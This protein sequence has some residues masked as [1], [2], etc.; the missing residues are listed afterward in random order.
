MKST[1]LYAVIALLIAAA[2]AAG[3]VTGAENQKG[4][5]PMTDLTK[6]GRI[7][8]PVITSIYTADPSA[9]VGQDGRLYVYASHDMDPARGCDFMDRY[10]VFSTE[11]MVHFRDEGEI[12]RSDDVEWGRP[13]GGFMWAP[14]CAFKN[15]KYWFYYPHPTGSRWNDT[16]EF[17]VAVS[18][19]PNKD[20]R[21][22]GYV[23]DASGRGIGG[24]ALIDPCIFIDDDGANYFYFGGGSKPRGCILRDDMIT[25]RGR[26]RPMEGL[27]DFHEASWVFK[28]NGIYYMT[29][30]DNLPGN[31]RL[32]YAVSKNPLGPWEYKG[33]YLAPTGCDTS[34]GSVTEYKGHWYA[35]YH[36]SSVSGQ[37]NL[38]SVCVDEL[39]FE[40]DDSIRLVQQTDRACDPVGPAPVADPR[41][42][43]Y[44][45]EEAVREGQ[46][47]VSDS[48]VRGFENAGSF[49]RFSKTDGYDGGR[50]SLCI[51]YAN[52]SGK[53]T[54][55]RLV[56]NSADWSLINL[57]PTGGWEDFG[58]AYFTVPLKKGRTNTIDITGFDG[59]AAVRSLTVEPLD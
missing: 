49:L 18:D 17:G 3:P 9:V 36:N 58:E 34:H 20:F 59:E 19:F 54:R 57:V 42:K 56:V 24:D 12:L 2:A 16:W 13:E 40:D 48:S 51:R 29:Y 44:A 52:G 45:A 28:R 22:L 32:R 47:N 55:V 7:A 35:F 33:I 10:H 46:L 23:R 25:V 11:D 31:N 50:A 6:P 1:Y 27:E 43:T 15:G 5:D 21:D 30:S 4:A 38:R 26:V 39:F 14:D 41:T 8:K 37:G 53:L